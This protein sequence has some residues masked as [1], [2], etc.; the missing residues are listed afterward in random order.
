MCL[1]RHTGQ[2]PSF[3]VSQML[4]GIC[5]LFCQS[6]KAMRREGLHCG[7]ERNQFKVTKKVSGHWIQMVFAVLIRG[8]ILISGLWDALSPGFL[9]KVPGTQQNPTDPRWGQEAPTPYSCTAQGAAH[10]PNI[11][12]TLCA[13]IYA[14]WLL[15][16]CS[17]E[18][19]VL[20]VQANTAPEWKRRL[21]FC[22]CHSPWST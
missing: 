14:W 15:T 13:N 17:S 10:S 7:A 5:A 6:N 9:L 8:P 19:I 2:K 11:C 1:S 16:T 22:S 21:Q 20:S 12:F 3:L 4:H 18:L